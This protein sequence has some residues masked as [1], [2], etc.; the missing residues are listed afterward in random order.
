MIVVAV[1]IVMISF[2]PSLLQWAEK[3]QFLEPLWLLISLIGMLILFLGIDLLNRVE[4]YKHYSKTKNPAEEFWE[5]D[6]P[7]I[8]LMCLK[9]SIGFMVLMSVVLV[10][11]VFSRT[12][13]P[14][15]PDF[16]WIYVTIKILGIGIG[17]GSLTM[18]NVIS[19]L[20]KGKTVILG[21]PVVALE[22]QKRTLTWQDILF[23][24]KPSFTDHEVDLKEDFD[25]IT[26]LDNPA[27]PWFMWLFYST[28]VFAVIYFVN[29]TWLQYG[30]SQIEEY[31]ASYAAYEKD[32]QEYLSKQEGNVDENTV[33]LETKPEKLAEAGKIFQS[34]CATCHGP[35]GGGIEGSGPNLT[36]DYWIHGNT[37]KNVFKTIKYGVL[38]AGMVPWEGQIS[39][40][41]MKAVASY[42]LSLRGTNPKS[43]IPPK[44]EKMAPATE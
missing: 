18:L 41:N 39:P 40:A 11:L 28:I 13:F 42:V 7:G 20:N 10:L 14:V 26:E 15:P 17:V 6:Y 4:V 5:Q 34:K 44:G 25:G 29:Y 1:P 8:R 24:I 22:R 36:D 38:S 2:Y 30:P 19:G 12:L 33:T 27:P 3:K 37:V 35:E 43:A 31:Q 9:Y 21:I 32:K 23:Q 16:N